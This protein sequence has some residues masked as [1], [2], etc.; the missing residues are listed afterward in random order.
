MRDYLKSTL[1]I[2]FMPVWAFALPIHIDGFYEGPPAKTLVCHDPV[3]LPGP[4]TKLSESKRSELWKQP[5]DFTKSTSLLTLTLTTREGS[6]DMD[7]SATLEATGP[8]GSRSLSLEALTL[9]PTKFRIFQENHGEK[10]VELDEDDRM[11]LA[12]NPDYQV[13]RPRLVDEV[14]P[15]NLREIIKEK[16]AALAL[17]LA[18]QDKEVSPK[19]RRMIE[20]VIDRSVRHYQEDPIELYGW[21]QVAEVFANSPFDRVTTSRFSLYVRADLR[22][23]FLLS[24]DER[25]LV[26]CQPAES[27]P[28]LGQHLKEWLTSKPV[29]KLIETCG[30]QL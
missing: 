8:N 14:T 10:M 29:R 28:N 2:L 18:T 24:G 12:I 3:E 23:A 7:P 25:R 1:V 17:I 5:A 22:G 26:Y 19:Q 13:F 21:N 27:A 6:F 20:E 4:L 11:I 16:N 9:S 30:A 15:E